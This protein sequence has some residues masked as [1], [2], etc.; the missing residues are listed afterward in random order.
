MT[1]TTKR[2]R[3]LHNGGKVGLTVYVLPDEDD[4]IRV[5]AAVAGFRSKS[6]YLADLYRRDRARRERKAEK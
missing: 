6:E 3:F 2:T 5:H 1:T 4:E